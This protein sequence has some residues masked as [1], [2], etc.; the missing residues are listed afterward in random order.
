VLPPGGSG[1]A[2][3]H[4]LAQPVPRARN[5]DEWMLGSKAGIKRLAISAITGGV[6]CL[7]L[8]VTPPDHDFSKRQPRSRA[9]HLPTA[10]PET[11]WSR[12]VSPSYASQG[13]VPPVPPTNHQR[14]IKRP[15]RRP[16]DQAPDLYFQVAGGGM[17][18]RYRLEESSPSG[19][20]LRLRPRDP[21][22]GQTM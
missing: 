7:K 19:S 13:P 10:A 8:L 1:R 2:P 14:M 15:D 4:Q 18:R 12:A 3:A 9:V 20:D 5:G 21:V 22:P 17:N 6:E 11:V 16:G